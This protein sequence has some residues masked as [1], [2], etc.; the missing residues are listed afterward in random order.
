MFI[1]LGNCSPNGAYV[2]FEH[3]ARHNMLLH[4]R[5][6]GTYCMHSLFEFILFGHVQL[7]HT[8]FLRL[9]NGKQRIQYLVFVIFFLLSS[10]C[11]FLWS[12]FLMF[13]AQQYHHYH[14]HHFINHQI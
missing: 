14:H 9:S 4:R 8:H 1:Q 10:S 12:Y 6:Y 3:S 7:I 5:R 13:D 2:T 11:R